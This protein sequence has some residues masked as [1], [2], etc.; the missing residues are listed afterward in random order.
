MIVASNRNRGSK[1]WSRGWWRKKIGRNIFKDESRTVIDPLLLRRYFDQSP[2]VRHS[3]GESQ[4]SRAETKTVRLVRLRYDWDGSHAWFWT[5][6]FR[7]KSRREDLMLFNRRFGIVMLGWMP[8]LNL[9]CSGTAW[10]SEQCGVI[11]SA[12]IAAK[13]TIT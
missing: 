13:V 12:K 6:L 7:F 11:L 4:S 3:S 1:R 9:L 8:A 10:R 2:I 5:F